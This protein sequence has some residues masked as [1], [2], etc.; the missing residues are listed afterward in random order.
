MFENF[1]YMEHKKMLVKM[2]FPLNAKFYSIVL[3]SEGGGNLQLSWH[4]D[5]RWVPLYAI[6]VT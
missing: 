5:Q 6:L 1:K 2:D 3:T 4:S